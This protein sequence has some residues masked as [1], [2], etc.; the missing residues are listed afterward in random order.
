MPFI[1]QDLIEG[2]SKP[3]TVLAHEPAQRGLELM[4]ENSFS[5]LP[6]VDPANKP[7]GLVTGD[8]IL[9]GV[10]NLRI[11]LDRLRIS[12]V[13]E[14]LDRYYPRDYPIFDLLNG[15]NMYPAVLIV[16]TDGE[17]AGIV[18]NWDTADYFRK[19]AIDTMMLEDVEDL[20]KAHIR[21]AFSSHQP[22]NA[23][24]LLEAAINEIANSTERHS[25]DIK[26]ALKKYF[27]LA[28][29]NHSLRE[30]VMEAAFSKIIGRAGATK[31]LDDLTLYEF[32]ELILYKPTWTSY[33]SYLDIPAE[34]LRQLLDEIR[35]SRNALAHFKR[36]ISEW[37]RQ[38]IKHCISLLQEIYPPPIIEAQ[39]ST[40]SSDE[41][42]IIPIDEELITKDSMYAPLAVYLQAQPFEVD[43]LQKTFEEIEHILGTKL[44][45]SARAHRSWWAN[46]SVSHV[47]S[48]QWLAAGWRVAGVNMT[49]GVITFSRNK[50]R[51]EAYINFFSA[52]LNELRA[53]ADFEVY[54]VSPGG[55]HWTTAKALPQSSRKLAW[56]NFAFTQKQQFRAELYIDTR[57]QDRNKRIFEKLYEQKAQIESD[58]GNALS[59]ERLDS[60][61]ACR[62][63]AYRD[64]FITDSEEKLAAIRSWGVREMVRFEQAISDKAEEVIQSVL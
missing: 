37:E 61:R 50:E 29:I 52:L 2:R 9:R 14:K 57:D 28:G 48:Q 18:T 4:I 7:L 45:D 31:K 42:E 55:T 39:I 51:E 35:D 36:E 24:K 63:A 12:H 34:S 32:T 5:Q 64:G 30:D 27:N 8:S 40:S 56:L 49:E 43:R 21:A 3:T 11:P 25:K 58:F 44:P 13:L 26:G 6:V 54:D 10:A 41:D 47:Q 59:W 22:Q 19:R 38:R 53:K 33:S 17:L 1:A 23:D 62:I 16:D 46:D 60:R 20:L 15:L